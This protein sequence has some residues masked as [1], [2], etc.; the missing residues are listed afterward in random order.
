MSEEPELS[1]EQELEN[2]VRKTLKDAN[3]DGV[4][5]SERMEV[6]KICSQHYVNL[7]KLKAKG[8]KPPG[9]EN[10][11]TM[12]VLRNSVADSEEEDEVDEQ[13]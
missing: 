7:E 8:G 11:L 6:L 1:I 2:L 9:G 13:T 3:M 12:A 4:K 5:L 10:G